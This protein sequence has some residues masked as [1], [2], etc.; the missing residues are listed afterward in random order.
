MA[1][2]PPA[3]SAMRRESNSLLKVAA[4]VDS[5]LEV[6]DVDLFRRRL[7]LL[8]PDEVP[9]FS[10]PMRR[11]LA[12]K[13]RALHRN[14]RGAVELED[15]DQIVKEQV[16]QAGPPRLLMRCLVDELE[17]AWWAGA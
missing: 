12:R 16:R 11:E 4:E 14:V 15:W 6:E 2:T 17:S 10:Q 13:I 5:T 8:K 7:H 3:L 9:V 1:M